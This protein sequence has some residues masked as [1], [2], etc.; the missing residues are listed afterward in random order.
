MPVGY[1]NVQTSSDTVFNFKEYISVH[2]DSSGK[3]LI[4][5]VRIEIYRIDMEFIHV[6]VFNCL[7]VSLCLLVG[8]LCIALSTAVPYPRTL[9]LIPLVGDQQVEES[10]FVPRTVLP[11]SDLQAAATGHGT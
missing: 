9:Q 6:N 8:A 4:H 10:A 5:G 7:Q 1:I 3:T 2:H 11:A